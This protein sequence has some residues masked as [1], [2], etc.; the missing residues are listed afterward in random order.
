M[1]EITTLLFE[2]PGK[3]N[4]EATLQAACA[5]AEQLGLRQVVVATCT[6]YTAVEAARVFG[7]G[8]VIGVTLSRRF[9]EVYSPPDRALIE[10]ARRLGAQVITCSHALMGAIDSAVQAKFGGLP[11]GDFI[12]QVYYTLSQGTKVAVEVSLSAADAGLLEMDKEVL[13]IAGTNAGADTALVLKPAYT[14]TF[15]DLRVLEVLAKPREG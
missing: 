6:G 5:R 8:R 13:A 15:F 4:T 9:W 3:G 1:A 12:A 14:N 7:P 10:E 11:P 2:Q